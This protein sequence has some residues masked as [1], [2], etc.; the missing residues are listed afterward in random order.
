M[1][2]ATAAHA[3]F[4]APLASAQGEQAL[5]RSG[6]SYTVIRPGRLLDAVEG[7]E[8]A[9]RVEQGDMM[10]GGGGIP[11][12]EVA[13]IAVA[14]LFDSGA[15]RVTFEVTRTS[16]PEP[17]STAQ[18]MYGGRLAAVFRGLVKDTPVA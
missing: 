9:W 6:V 2:R 12:A 4:D 7:P 10:K 3:A 14:A 5:R 1:L 11:L 18:Q 8:C 15:D 16:P 17:P 13:A